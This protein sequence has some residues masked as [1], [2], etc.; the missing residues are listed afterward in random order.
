MDLC[1][2]KFR[3]L[4][5][6]KWTSDTHERAPSHTTIRPETQVRAHA[7]ANSH[8]I[9]WLARVVSVCLFRVRRATVGKP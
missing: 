3:E 5:E 2:D 6:P 7:R 4:A 9:H 8:A 1:H